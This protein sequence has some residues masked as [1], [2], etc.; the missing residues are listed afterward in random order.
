MISIMK[1]IIFNKLIVFT[2]C[3]IGALSLLTSCNKDD[4]NKTVVLEAFGP[5]PILRG[6]NMFIIGS[7]LDKIKSVVFQVGIEVTNITVVNS[8]KIEVPVP[9]EATEGKITIKFDGGVIVSKSLLTFT[10]PYSITSISPVGSAIRAGDHVTITGDYLYN[11]TSVVFMSNAPVEA[12]GTGFVLQ[13]RKEIVVAVPKEA[14]SGKIKITDAAGNELYSDQELTISQQT[15]TSISPLNIKAGTVLTING[16]NLDLVKSI[17]FA[18]GSSVSAEA[19]TLA[20]ATKIQVTVPSDAKD[21]TIKTIAWSGTEVVSNASLDMV[22]PS[23]LAF[24]VGS[25]FKAGNRISITGNNLDLVTALKFS[26]NVASIFTYAPGS[27]SVTIPETAVDGVITLTTDAGKSVTTTEITLAKP[28]ITSLAP[29]EFTAGESFTVTG[30]NLDLVTGVKVNGLSCTITSGGSTSLTVS[31]PLTTTSGKVTL[32]LANGVS[33]VSDASLT[34]NASTKPTVTTM[35]AKARP[36]E[37]ISLLGTNLN[38]VEAVYFGTTKVMKY[39]LRS[40]ARLQFTIPKE[41]PLGSYKIKL[42]PYEGE[43]VMTTNS[44]TLSGQEPIVDASLV[45][46]DFEDVSWEWGLWGGVGQ[47]ASED[48]N[49]FYKGT[50]TAAI[51][52]FTWLW[53]NNNIVLPGCPNIT[54]Y[55]V[56]FDMKILNDFVVGDY[57]IQMQLG[58]DQWGWCTSGFF[59]LAADGVTA[60]T[61][62]GWMTVTIDF[63]TLGISGAPATGKLQTGMAAAYSSFDWANVCLDNFR[64]QLK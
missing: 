2:L 6:T 7:N 40:E 43:D 58:N 46:A 50:T 33:V 17:S 44:I 8:S 62:G 39:S 25:I 51:S 10:E 20:T 41:T 31:T 12:K 55:V 19:F 63:A 37:E 53:A 45:F 59:P 5:S 9:Q 64:Y 1:R 61:G 28:A 14:K 11:I 35:P 32:T 47:I 26:D 16:T 34:V 49:K 22:V 15:I 30:T 3:F 42:V 4:D 56:K 13:S 24:A 36:G 27:V 21:G 23:D 38:N 29:M 60:T 54:D 52:G 48:G 57:A 18:G